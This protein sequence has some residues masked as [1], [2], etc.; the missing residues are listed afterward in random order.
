[1]NFHRSQFQAMASTN[2]VQLFLDNNVHAKQALQR[3]ADEVKR[4]ERKYSR[5]RDDSVTSAINAMAG[6]RW[7]DIDEETDGLL[8][9]ADAC[10]RLSDGLFDITSGVLRR[11]WDYKSGRPPEQAVLAALLPLV[12]WH[13]VERKQGQVYLPLSGME[14]DFGGVG[15]EYAVDRAAAILASMGIASA[16]ISLGGDI[17]VLGPRPDG[18]PWP[19]FILHPREHDRFAATVHLSKGALATSG[20]YQRFFDFEGRRYSHILHPDTGQPSRTWQSVTIVSAICLDAG[21]IA[22]IAMLKEQA[23]PAFLNQRTENALLIDQSGRMQGTGA[24][25]KLA[26]QS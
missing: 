5:Y 4:I 1:V 2:E 6:V 10:Y 17:R 14:I 20:D 25:A 23:A 3:V 16:L 21:S 7:C 9:H 18:S 22:T 12:G 8:H 26:S 11:A 24:L 19:V 15:K 13:K